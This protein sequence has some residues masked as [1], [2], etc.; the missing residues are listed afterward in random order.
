MI[1]YKVNYSNLID[2][3][4]LIKLILFIILF[5]VSLQMFHGEHSSVG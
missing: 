4:L 5:Y 2:Y 3:L 1:M